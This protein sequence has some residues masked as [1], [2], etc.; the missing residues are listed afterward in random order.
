VQNKKP[1]TKIDIRK[2]IWE[3]SLLANSYGSD[4]LLKTWFLGFYDRWF[5]QELK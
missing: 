3:L 1:A 2:P 4:L 5:F